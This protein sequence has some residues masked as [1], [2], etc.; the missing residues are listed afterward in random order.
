[1]NGIAIISKN[2]TIMLSAIMNAKFT[3]ILSLLLVIKNKLLTVC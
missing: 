1:M 3:I 2:I